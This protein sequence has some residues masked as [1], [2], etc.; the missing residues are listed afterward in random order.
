MKRAKA[1][2]VTHI[3]DDL[4]ETG[5][6]F[7]EAWRTLEKGGKVRERHLSFE[8]LEGLL[9]L[10]TPKRWALLKHVHRK[11][12]PSIRALSLQLKR[13]YRRVHDD[14]E[15]LAA[16]GLLE[17]DGRTVRAG[18]DSIESSFRFDQPRAS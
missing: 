4:V 2:L 18:Y 17:R 8:S 12:V 14:V 5:R 6:R 13:D 9:S 10:L 16:A 7:I 11:P 15:A 1:I 3:G